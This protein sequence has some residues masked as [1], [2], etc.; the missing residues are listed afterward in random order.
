MVRQGRSWRAL[1]MRRFD[2]QIPHVQ[3]ESHGKHD[4]SEEAAIPED[5]H[6]EAPRGGSKGEVWTGAGR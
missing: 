6:S 2:S 5:D 3:S 1:V 4:K